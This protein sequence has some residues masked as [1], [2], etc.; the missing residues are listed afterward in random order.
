[1]KLTW[2]YIGQCN[3][4]TIRGEND[5]SFHAMRDE[6]KGHAFVKHSYEDAFSN[7]RTDHI[8]LCLEFAEGKAEEVSC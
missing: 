8:S 5:D 2:S 1:M 3:E 7:L 4:R 6:K